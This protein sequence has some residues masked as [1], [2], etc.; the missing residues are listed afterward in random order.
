MRSHTDILLKAG[1]AEVA[2]ER[3]VSIH[4]ARSWATRDSI[5]AEHWQGFVRKGWASL[6]E[7]AAYAA[8]SPRKRPSDTSVAA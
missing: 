3:S 8:A 2:S 7:L 6:E 4:T 1:V 5:P